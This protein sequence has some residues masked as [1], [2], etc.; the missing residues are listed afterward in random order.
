[1][2]RYRSH[3]ALTVWPLA[4][5]VA[6]EILRLW[7]AIHGGSAFAAASP[8]SWS[9]LVIWTVAIFGSLAAYARGWGILR[10]EVPGNAGPYRSYGCWRLQKLAGGLGWGLVVAQ[11]LLH[12]VM[13]F[14]VGPVA[15]SQYELLRGFLSRPPVFAFYLLGLGAI[16][17]FLS[18]GFA[19]SFRAWGV[20]QR[21]E[22]SRW[23]EVG[24]TLS[25][26]MLLLFAFNVLSHFVTGRAYWLGS[27]PEA[28]ES[29]AAPEDSAR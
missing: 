8:A 19:A 3:I 4:I 13:T 7:P 23:V 25:S 15:L 20:G 14:R 12:W 10:L 17:L 29:E 21:P 28:A 22:S 16:G 9:S 1:M 11:L 2:P 27:V 18:Q 5:I 24:G 6:L 26:V